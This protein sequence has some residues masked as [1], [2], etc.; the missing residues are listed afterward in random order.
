MQQKDMQAESRRLQCK[1]MN[2]RQLATYLGLHG[3]S[4]RKAASEGKSSNGVDRLVVWIKV[5]GI[6]AETNTQQRAIELR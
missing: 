2:T 5:D 4:S 3:E 6:A 1:A